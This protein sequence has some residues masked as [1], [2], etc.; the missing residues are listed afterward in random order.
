MT[1]EQ[2]SD[3]RVY[4]KLVVAELENLNNDQ[5]DHEKRLREIEKWQSEIKVKIAM[6]VAAATSIAT[7]VSQV[8]LSWIKNTPLPK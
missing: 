7:I 5:D 3:W 8:L 6:I 4:E 2:S 1:D